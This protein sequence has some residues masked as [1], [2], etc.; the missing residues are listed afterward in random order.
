MDDIISSFLQWLQKY[1]VL[2]STL[3]HNEAVELVME[4]TMSP[5][6]I[7]SPSN[8]NKKEQIASEAKK[9]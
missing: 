4:Y 6:R 3:Q 9:S 1:T 8:A 7:Y 5:N 2:T